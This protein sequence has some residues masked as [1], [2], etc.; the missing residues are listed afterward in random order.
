[1]CVHKE[2]QKAG[3]R[4]NCFF[5]KVL[6]LYSVGVKTIAG[7][8]LGKVVLFSF[9]SVFVVKQFAVFLAP[10]YHFVKYRKQGIPEF[11]NEILRAWRLFGIYGFQC[12]FVLHQSLSYRP[13][14]CDMVGN[15][16]LKLS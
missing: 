4:T 13:N 10:F 3:I 8:V 2:V 11:R 15:E 5:C 7:E 9:C 14:V 6:L 16:I 12:E 1:M